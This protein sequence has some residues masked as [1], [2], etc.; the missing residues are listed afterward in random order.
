MTKTMN[1][2]A[3]EEE[4]EASTP[5]DRGKE[6]HDAPAAKVERKHGGGVHGAHKHH[7]KGPKHHSVHR[8]RGGAMKEEEAAERKKGGVLPMDGAKEHESH[9]MKR[10][11]H[12]ARKHGGKIDGKESKHRPDRRARGGATSDLRPETAAGKM[13]LPDYLRQQDMP[14][15]KGKGADSRGRD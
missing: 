12:Q 8:R 4:K 5:G 3:M 7:M 9:E 2:E 15:S 14:K 1:E 10:F 6:E 11:H 13:A